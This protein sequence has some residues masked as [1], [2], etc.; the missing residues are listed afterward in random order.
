MPK[1]LDEFRELQDVS[2]RHGGKKI[3]EGWYAIAQRI[4]KTGMAYTVKEVWEMKDLVNKRVGQYRTKNA[5]DK[6]CEEGKLER[7]YDG[8]RFWYGPPEGTK[9]AKES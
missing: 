3:T 9:V 6:L 5:L 4:C 8:K 1:E 7:M 2:E